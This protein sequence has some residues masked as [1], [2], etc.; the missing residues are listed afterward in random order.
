MLFLRIDGATVRVKKW[1]FLFF[2]GFG[3]TILPQ[4]NI[5]AVHNLKTKSLGVILT[6]WAMF[7]PV[8]AFLQCLVSEV[9]CAHL[10]HTFATIKKTFSKNQ[11]A[12]IIFVPDATF[13]PN[14]FLGLLSPEILL[15]KKQSTQTP[16]QKLWDKK[17]QNKQE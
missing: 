8:S 11:S 15:G 16:M 14:L 17:E 3:L 7:V 1:H 10:W 4:L 6:P 2:V 13:V 12:R 5:K 9:A